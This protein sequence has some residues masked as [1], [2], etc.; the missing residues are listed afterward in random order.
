M[1][2]R[3]STDLAAKRKPRQR[4]GAERGRTM[5]RLA[6][7]YPRPALSQPA[8]CG[9]GS[10]AIDCKPLYA[11]ESQFDFSSGGGPSQAGR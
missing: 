1:A 6:T 8:I 9:G 3:F 2:V 5:K 11:R 4:I 7:E 10:R